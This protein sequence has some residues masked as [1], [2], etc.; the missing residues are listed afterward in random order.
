MRGIRLDGRG[1]ALYKFTGP[2]LDKK[3]SRT[4]RGSTKEQIGVTVAICIPGCK[5]RAESRHAVREEGL[6]TEIVI[7]VLVVFEIESQ[8]ALNPGEESRGALGERLRSGFLFRLGQPVMTAFA[9]IAKLLEATTR[10][11]DPERFDGLVT[12]EPKMRHW[13]AS[14]HVSARAGDDPGE[15]H[16]GR[17][18]HFNPGAEAKA[19]TRGPA[20]AHQDR[21]RGAGVV[22][23][24]AHRVVHVVDHYIK[25]SIS[26]E[27]GQDRAVADRFIAEAPRF[28]HALKFHPAPVAECEV[29]LR[30]TRTA[31]EDFAQFLNSC[32]GILCCGHAVV[33]VRVLNVTL[34]TVGKKRVLESVVVQ[35]PKQAAPGP[36]GAVEAG[37]ERNVDEFPVAGVNLHGVAHVL[38]WL[39]IVEEP[40]GVG[41]RAHHGLL[42]EMGGCRHVGAQVVEEPVVV[43]VGK[44]AAH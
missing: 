7:V 10:P 31:E 28:S 4:V 41:H 14:A 37:K 38:A 22:A 36:V 21:P 39:E 9:E 16:P 35:V 18:L 30:K 33:G 19:I 26:I 24:D 29:A 2:I 40:G 17:E 6:G 20:Q 8:P 3:C 42:L 44:V 12:A 5:R 11:C 23:I 25:V 32:S 1:S 15:G 13:F 27:I 34:D 43:N